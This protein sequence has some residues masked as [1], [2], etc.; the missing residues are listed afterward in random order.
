MLFNFRVHEEYVDDIEYLTK[1]KV[2]I[3]YETNSSR[4]HYQ[5]IVEYEG[6]TQA[7]TKELKRKNPRVVGN[8]AYSF[9]KFKNQH[10]LESQ[11]GYY[12]KEGD[13]RY[14]TLGVTQEQIDLQ[15]TLYLDRP[16]KDTLYGKVFR[17]VKQVK[18][19]LQE[20]TDYV[21]KYY[22]DNEKLIDL[23]QIEKL[24]RTYQ[25]N[26]DQAYLRDLKKRMIQKLSDV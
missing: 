22:V 16:Q 19:S 20:T 14:N 11:V 9:T 3:A 4:P 1:Y 5:G 17:D 21:F 18:M 15:K 23:F 26:H 12:S 2:F 13:I 6:T 8:Q 10:T 25:A 24:I 7:F